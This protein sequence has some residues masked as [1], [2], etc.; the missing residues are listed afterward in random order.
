MRRIKSYIDNNL[1]LKIASFN[2]VAIVV[3]IIS[4]LL[5][6]KAIAI[7]VGA[8][9]MALVGNL[10]NFLTTI[11][12]FTTLGFANGIV[13]YI[14]EFKDDTQKLSK[15]ISTVAK[16]I[17][18]ATFFV[19]LGSYFFAVNIN[20]YV[21]NKQ[22][23]YVYVIKIFAFTLPFHAVNIFFISVLN[24][25]SKHKLFIKINIFGQILGLLIT[26]LL[27]Y[28]CHIDGALI[29]IVVLPFILFF[30][31]ILGYFEF[32]SFLKPINFQSIHFNT[33]KNLSSYSVMAFFTS[34]M[35]PLVM[36]T[37]RNYLMDTVGKEEAGYW[38]AML[39]IS[40]YYLMF[41]NTL[42]TLYLLP[43]LSA[44]STDKAFRDEVFTFYKFIVPVFAFGL[45]II[46]FLRGIIIHI[47]FTDE[48]EP[49]KDLFF[50]QLLG[51]FVKVLSM[52]LA[53]QFLAKKMIWHYLI[54]EALSVTVLYIS[55]MYL[56]DIYGFE[57]ASMAH[58]VVYTCYL[59]LLLIIFRKALFYKKI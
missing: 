8:E 7:F 14:A 40:N 25:L 52:V 19:A 10:R 22:Y 37:I 23:D 59:C 30:V 16:S 49:V 51:D 41:V 5:T 2:S 20:D 31:L 38:E 4:G 32:K 53:Y 18:V 29:A 12:S 17:F 35:I 28:K 58:F 6:S 11:Y 45:I 57:G 55:S 50:W 24:G 39:R 26:L 54:T 47:I 1:L 42:M 43:K 36:I 44:I 34:I 3:R 27:I 15:T 13:K 9:G 21:F 48:F 56:I 33:L 46:Y